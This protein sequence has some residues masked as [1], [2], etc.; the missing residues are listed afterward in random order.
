MD[1]KAKILIVDDSILSRTILNRAI[2]Q[3][4]DAECVGMASSGKMALSKIK[5]LQPDLVILDV[6]MPEMDGI[7]TLSKLKEIAPEIQVA[8]ISS[9]DMKTVKKTL[10]FLQLGAIDFISKPTLMDSEKSI[11]ELSRQISFLIQIVITKKYASLCRQQILPNPTA[12]KAKSAIASAKTQIELVVIGIS[13][14]GPK[15]LEEMLPSLG[16]EIPCPILIVQHM[17]PLFTGF[18][19]ERLAQ[20]ICLKIKEA[21]HGESI[22][23]GTLYIAVGGRHLRLQKNLENGFYLSLDDSPPINNCR[24]SVDVLFSSVAEVMKENILA[25]VMTGMGKDGTEGVRALKSKKN[26]F[27]LI[28]DESS[29]VVWGMPGSVYTANLADE[30]LPLESLGKR[31]LELI[32]R[33]K[34]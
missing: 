28:Q 5:Q 2:E 29:S 15:A 32:T 12:Q 20:H 16:K 31:I 27:C 6:M 24:P 22:Q 4:A 18:L 11:L 9:A 7:E 1:P 10:K 8:M 30:V 21:E 3:I 25:V 13:T 17:P 23:N 19:A 33:I 26:N 14:G 34:N